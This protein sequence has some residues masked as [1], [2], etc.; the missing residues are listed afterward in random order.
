MKDA[1]S[2]PTHFLFW[3]GANLVKDEVR[4]GFFAA[5]TRAKLSLYLD[6]V[7][8][9]VS[10]RSSMLGLQLGRRGKEREDC[11]LGRLQQKSE[12]LAQSEY[13]V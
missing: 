5:G 3:F 1:D 7:R 13:K 8:T 9:M 6:I 12:F 2:N 4:G 10:G 11:G